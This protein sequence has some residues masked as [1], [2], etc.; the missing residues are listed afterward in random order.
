MV[1]EDGSVETLSDVELVLKNAGIQLRDSANE[2]RD[3]DDV[4]DDTA[5]R[6]ENLS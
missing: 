3:F 1:D 6:W 5:K 4:L 2:F